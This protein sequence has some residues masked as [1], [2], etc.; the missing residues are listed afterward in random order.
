MGIVAV[1]ATAC[2]SATPA[3]STSVDSTP[4]ATASGA[5]QD[6]ANQA[7]QDAIAGIDAAVYAY[8]VVG[9]HVQGSRRVL[10]MHAISTLDRQ[11]AAMALALGRT[12]DEAGVAYALPGPVTNPAQASALAQ[13]LEMKLI[14]LFDDVAATS[15][16]ATHLLG[17][18]ASRKAAERAQKWQ[19]AAGQ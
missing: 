19:R 15:S 4:T 5:N 6:A 10:A 17:A 14:P 13:L 7:L 1:M 11:R 12:V 2:G 9:A 3:T 18:T 8:G 16:G